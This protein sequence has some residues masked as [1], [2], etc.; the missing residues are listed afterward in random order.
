MKVGLYKHHFFQI[1]N[2]TFLLGKQRFS[3]LDIAFHSKNVLRIFI[4]YK[5]TNQGKLIDISWY[6]NTRMLI[7]ETYKVAGSI[8]EVLRYR[9]LRFKTV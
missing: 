3:P 9:S 8:H 1:Y 7:R 5:D 6:T 4:E 2:I